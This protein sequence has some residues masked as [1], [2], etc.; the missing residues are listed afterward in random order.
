MLPTS[1]QSCLCGTHRKGTLCV[2]HPQAVVKQE[3]LLSRTSFLLTRCRSNGFP[4]SY[5]SGFCVSFL[6][7]LR[8]F[9]HL[10]D[11]IERS[12]LGLDKHPGEILSHNA[13]GENVHA[14]AK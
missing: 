7:C 1:R 13:Q 6:D 9:V 12:L 5:R 8:R 11:H 2:G 3:F 14:A 4:C 10:T